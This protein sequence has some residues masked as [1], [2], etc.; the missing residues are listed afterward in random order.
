MIQSSAVKNISIQ[1]KLSKTWLFVLVVLTISL[2]LVWTGTSDLQGRVVTN[3][4]F[5][6][7]L[8][9]LIAFLTPYILFPDSN[10]AVIQLGN[11]SAVSISSYTLKKI[12]RLIWP[13]YL[14]IFLIFFGD[15]QTP[16]DFISEKFILFASS[17]FLLNGVMLFSIVRYAKSGKSSRF[18]KESAKENGQ[19]AFSEYLKY[20]QVD[21]SSLPSL[22]NTILVFLVGAISIVIGAIVQ[23][24][25]GL[26]FELIFY[27]IIFIYGIYFLKKHTYSFDQNFYSSDSFFR[28]FFGSGSKTEQATSKREVEQL[29]WVP[30][31]LKMHVWQFLLQIDRKIPA[32]RAVAAGH[33]AVWFIAYQR[34]D[35]QFLTVIWILFALAHQLFTIMSIQ[36]EIAPYWMLRW[37]DSPA[38]WTLSRFWMQLRWLVPLVLSMNVQFFLFGVPGF[39][40]QSIILLIY[41]LSAL[42]T[43]IIGTVKLKQDLKT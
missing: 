11:F 25:Y 19:K 12:L 14:L 28:E 5:L 22:I 38:I 33:A 39:T 40:E 6:F 15:L 32:G 7:S 16:L 35:P 26:Y 36:K 31:R 34:P 37:V 21:P 17:I 43:S 27:L 42:F 2:G 3:R 10:L 24:N 23:Q 13:I 9:A 30:A 1:Q 18:W 29:W 41:I 4:Y 20:N 8:T